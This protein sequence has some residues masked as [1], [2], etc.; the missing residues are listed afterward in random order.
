M[1]VQPV[2]A[3]PTHNFGC[4]GFMLFLRSI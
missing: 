3:R 1:L 4:L 2:I